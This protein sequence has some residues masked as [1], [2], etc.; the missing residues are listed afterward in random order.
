MDVNNLKIWI[1]VVAGVL[2]T[3]GYLAGFFK[4][5]WSTIKRIIVPFIRKML[6]DSDFVVILYE[7][8]Q[9]PKVETWWH[10]GKNKDKPGMQV[11]GNFLVT[12]NSKN[13]TLLTG[14]EL[15][16]LKVRGEVSVKEVN[17]QYHSSDYKI[18]P[19]CTTKMSINF[20]I[21]PPMK[22]QGETFVE[23]VAILDQVGKKYWIKKVE[24][25]YR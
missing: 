24:F 23:D 13:Y 19:G 21:E 6:T 17:S 7:N 8:T 16:K 12:N 9:F 4:W 15:K 18:P 2:V 14:A 25:K 20:W 22:K 3:I 1:S 10:M 11:V 5:L